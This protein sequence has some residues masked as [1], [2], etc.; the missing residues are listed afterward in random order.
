MK[1]VSGKE[2]SKIGIGTYGIGGR[3]HRDIPITEKQSDEK[4]IEAL[5]YQF[6]KG[7][8]FLEIA[9]GYGQGKS[10]ELLKRALDKSFVK[11][12]DLL[13]THSLYP[14]DMESFATVQA[15]IE[16]FYQTIETDYAD[17]TLVTLSL[18]KKFGKEKVYNLLRELLENNKTRYVSLSNSGLTGIQDFK[19]EF[20]DKFFAHEGHLSFEVRAL[21]DKGIFNLCNELGVKNIIWRPLRRNQTASFNWELLQELSNKYQKSQNQIILNWISSLG[22]Y[23]MIM[24]ANK[25]H[26]DEIVT[27]LEFEMDPED[28]AKL[29]NFRPP[30]YFP[31]EVDW[32]KEGDGDSIVS[33]VIDFE[34]HIRK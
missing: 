23:P 30:N 33:L 22:Y 6:E 24:S 15:D 14:R 5:I 2:M 9:I 7:F 13:L 3:G 11:R 10:I 27:S 19:N 32:D 20:G 34:S 1:T 17:S 4:Y 31:P 16:S 12:E 28:Y 21:Q 26:I 29:T 25:K 8:N 18:I